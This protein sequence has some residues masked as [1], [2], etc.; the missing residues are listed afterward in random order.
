[1]KGKIQPYLFSSSLSLLSLVS[2]L[3]LSCILFAP[4]FSGFRSHPPKRNAL[5]S[6][7]QKRFAGLREGLTHLLGAGLVLVAFRLYMMGLK[8][9][10]FA[11]ADN[12]ASDSDCFL[13]RTL[14]FL[15]LPA[16]NFWLLL[17][18]RWL[19]FDWSME[20]IPLIQSLNDIRNLAS[21]IFYVTLYLI[22]KS[23][24]EHLAISSNGNGSGSSSDRFRWTSSLGSCAL[25][26]NSSGTFSNNSTGSFGYYPYSTSNSSMASSLFNCVPCSPYFYH[27]H[28]HHH[29]H[30]NTHHHHQHHHH[31]HHNNHVKHSRRS[32]NIKPTT[33]N[34][35]SPC[36][37]IPSILSSSSI[38]HDELPVPNGC[39]SSHP[40]HNGYSSG[41]SHHHQNVN[42][43]HNGYHNNGYSNFSLNGN[44]VRSSSTVTAASASAAAAAAAEG[45]RECLVGKGDQC[46]SRTDALTMSLAL[47]VLPFIPATNLFF[48]VGFVVAERILYIP[49]MGFCL[50]VAIGMNRF[51]KRKTGRLVALTAFSVLLV[52]LSVRTFRR[53]ID[54]HTEENLYRSGIPINPPKGKLPSH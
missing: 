42:Y 46:F 53:N 28:H 7:K 19:S 11:P 1:M 36:N 29:H 27:Q 49:S 22:T 37:C 17:Y 18:P 3:F 9:P 4:R 23:V 45:E 50:L 31:H 6:R 35:N 32:M 38:E 2:L 33:N 47:L 41:S 39:C 51:T 8:P 21:I 54:W 26:P 34:N 25:T 10:D 13:T 24:Y 15:Y 5:F 48:Y 43:R 52:F 20:A 12:P 16:F 14:T 44:S 30:N 40:Y